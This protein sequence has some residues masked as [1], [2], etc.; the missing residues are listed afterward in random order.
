MT[1]NKVAIVTGSKK[2]IGYAIAEALFREGY[3][4]VLSGRDEKSAVQSIIDAL[5]AEGGRGFADWCKCDI[6]VTG[7]R[8]SLLNYVINKYGRVDLL[9]NNAGVAPTVRTDILQTTEES[10]DRLININT[11]GTFF[12]SQLFAKSMIEFKKTLVNYSPKII[13]IASISSYTVST[14][15]GEYCVSKA[16]LSMI[17]KM[18]AARLAE[19][20]ISVF[21]VRPGIILTDM[22]A[23]VRDKYEKL[24]AE[25][26]T[27]IGRIGTPKDVA[28]CVLAATSGL[29]DFGTGTVLNADGG[30]HIRRL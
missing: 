18:F 20:N 25:G 26:L 11:K 2:G 17:T 30:F 21:E 1:N 14:A 15:R 23:S 4:V 7:D 28:D 16:G 24:I 12:M 5:N 29:L 22:T 9:V 6:S 10:F 27:P 19:E 3:T 8:L 13:N